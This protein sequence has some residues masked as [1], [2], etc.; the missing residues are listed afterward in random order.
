MVDRHTLRAD[1]LAG[2][3]GAIILVPQ[4]VAFATIAGMPPEYGLYACMVPAIIAALFGSS[5]HLVTGP[6]TTGS[7]I[8][9]ASLSALAIPGSPD[10]IRLA[11]T[12]AFLT[13]AFQLAL[14]LARMGVLVNFVSQTVITAY[15]AGAAVWIFCSQLGNFFDVATPRGMSL[16]DLLQSFLMQLG[17]INPYTAAVGVVTLAA[18]LLTR[19]LW[20]RLP[21]MIV[22][23]VA[24]SVCAVALDQVFGQDVTNIRT[25][26]AIRQA[27]PPLSLPDFSADAIEATLLSALVLTVLTLTEAVSIA[28]AV[29]LRTDQVIDNNQTFIGQGLANVV[30]AF[31]SAYPSSGSFNRTGLNYEAGAKTPLSAIL[32]AVFLVLI[33]VALAP[34]ARYLP[35][36]S[37]AALLFMVAVGLVNVEQI[38]KAWHASRWEALVLV[39]TFVATLVDLRVSIFIGMALSLAVF[40]YHASRPTVST[41]VPHADPNSAHFVDGDGIVPDCPSLKIVRINGALYFGAA[42]YIQQALMRIDRDDPRHVNVL[43]V[44][45]GIHYIDAAGAQVLAQEARRRRK[46]GGALYFYRLSDTAQETLRRSGYLDDIG[47]ANLYPTQTGVLD[48]VKAAIA[49]RAPTA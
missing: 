8:V 31:F 24:G 43:I 23:I 3:T 2:L 1:A 27:L 29:A 14:G 37:M 5:W 30:G 21:H 13:G 49:A 26:G 33:L 32:G 35:I 34:L 25:V 15:V 41:A 16:V 42:N 48:S 45:R 17:D 4:G 40:V 28:R 7:L 22:A 36:T 38:R 10:Y 11:L 46:L 20:P 6:S 44:A 18:G 12:L 47:E 9:F 19:R 39:V